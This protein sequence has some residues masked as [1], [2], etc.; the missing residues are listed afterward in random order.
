LFD[1]E[2]ATKAHVQFQH[3]EK[4]RT[5][6]SFKKQKTK[7]QSKHKMRKKCE[8]EKQFNLLVKQ[9]DTSVHHHFFGF[10]RPMGLL[11]SG[12]LPP[13]PATAPANAGLAP[14]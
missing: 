14:D 10:L 9:M 4:L 8:N 1:E 3:A 6:M 5:M 13:N 12:T 11:P 7:K 2:N